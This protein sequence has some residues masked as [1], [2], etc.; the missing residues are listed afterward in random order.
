[1]FKNRSFYLKSDLIKNFIEIIIFQ[2]L[3]FRSHGHLFSLFL[4]VEQYFKEERD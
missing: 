2:N 1:M 4:K 3:D